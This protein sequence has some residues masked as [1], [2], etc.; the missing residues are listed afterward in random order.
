MSH[1]SSQFT[2]LI[3]D[4]AILCY[5]V[6]QDNA[7]L[8]TIVLQRTLVTEKRYQCFNMHKNIIILEPINLEPLIN[9]WAIYA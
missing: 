9:G 6:I 4:T 1:H 5:S 2:Y 7:I 8:Y 3:S